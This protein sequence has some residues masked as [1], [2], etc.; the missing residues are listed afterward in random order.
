MLL[1][2]TMDSDDKGFG[3][4]TTSN[5]ARSTSS[6][7]K[8][9]KNYI[10]SNSKLR[11]HKNEKKRNQKSITDAITDADSNTDTDSNT[12]TTTSGGYIILGMHRSGTSML[13]GLLVKGLGYNVGK[14]LIQP[15]YDNEKGFFEL[16]PAVLQNDNFL[17]SQNIWWNANVAKYDFKTS[18][19]QIKKREIPFQK[20]SKALSFLNDP[21]NYPW[22]LK[23]PRM[24]ITLLTWI[25]LIHTKPAIVFTYRHPMEVAKSLHTREA[26]ITISAGLRLWIHYNRLAIQNSNFNG[27]CRV[28]SSNVKLLHDQETEVQRISDELTHNCHVLPP[29]Q[30]K[31]QKEWVRNFMDP[32]LQHEKKNVNKQN[33]QYQLLETYHDCDILDYD[34]NSQEHDR[35]PT[36][37]KEREL[38]L[39]AMRI[40]CDLDSRKAFDKHYVWPQV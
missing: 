18:L 38:Y 3:S 29:N 25:D 26:G 36:M 17:N 37:Q 28:I 20:G 1:L 7:K 5:G 6:K 13:A 8:T 31:V 27:L 4:S 32:G 23:D 21:N 39:K 16:L 2:Q 11:G 15:A 9:T 24:C 22:L 10:D 34:A 40:Y 30:P 14:P 35:N 12:N 33:V 19:Q